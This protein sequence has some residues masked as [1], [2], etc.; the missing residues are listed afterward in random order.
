MQTIMRQLFG[1]G[2]SLPS[3]FDCGYRDSQRQGW[4]DRRRG[5]L[6]PGFAI[7]PTDVCVDVGCGKGGASM[8]A[9]RQGADVIATDIDP[10]VIAGVEAKFARLRTPWR[11]VVSDSDP[12]PLADGAATRVIAMEV[13]EHVPDPDRFVAELVRIGRP[14]TRYLISVPDERAEAVQKQIAPPAYWLPPNHLRVFAAGELEALLGR[15]GLVVERQ[16]AKSFYW[17]IWWILF[18][19]ADQELGEPE[20]PLLQAWTRTWDELLKIPRADH[21]RQALDECMPKSRVF[22]A[23]KSAPGAAGLPCS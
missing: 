1:R 20:G 19:A 17:A 23:Q 21:V 8:F 2:E 5:E 11:A 16:L 10:R 4:Y 3:C 18:W 15:H 7:G 12:L 22:I 6:A 13:L 14:G 9:A